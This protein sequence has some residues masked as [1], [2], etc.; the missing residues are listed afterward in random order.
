MK[1]S[2]FKPAKLYIG[3]IFRE[4]AVL[5]EC[6]TIIKKE[7]GEIESESQVFEFTQTDYYIKEMGSPLH[8]QFFVLKRLIDPSLLSDI[9]IFTNRIEDDFKERYQSKGRVINLDPGIIT[10]G[11][12]IVATAKNFSHRIPLKN[13]IY[14]HLEYMFTKKEVKELPWTYLDFRSEEYK[15]FFLKIRKKYLAELR[16]KGYK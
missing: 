15:N 2:K 3:T 5:E 13:G 14:A 10:A 16:E 11:S 6:L 12:M 7:Y 8:R 1:E 4:R 9:K